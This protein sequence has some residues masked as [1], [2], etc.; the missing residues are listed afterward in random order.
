MI[1]STQK[2]IL[3]LSQ[4]YNA[5]Y[6]TGVNTLSI[7]VSRYYHNDNSHLLLGLSFTSTKTDNHSFAL[8]T[9]VAL[10]LAK[11]SFLGVVMSTFKFSHIVK[12]CC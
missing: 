5:V 8:Q 1:S 11:V 2:V 3:L 7:F 4:Y 12:I 10:L 6:S 9:S